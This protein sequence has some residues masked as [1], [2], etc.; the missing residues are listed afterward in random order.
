M[1]HVCFL[2]AETHRPN[3]PLVFRRL[4]SKARANER[5]LGNHSLP[6]LLLPLARANDPEH[7]VV[8]HGSHLGQR[9][10][11]LARLLLSL[12]LDRV[13]EYLGPRDVLAIEQVAGDGT[14]LD[15]L[16]DLVFAVSL[17]VEFDR[18]LHGGLFLKALRIISLRPCAVHMLREL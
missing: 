15:G 8:G 1:H 11:P 17:L 9:H 10:L 18:F 4:A 6:R 12:L 3:E 16:L 2:E 5:D 14:G 7:L 13:G